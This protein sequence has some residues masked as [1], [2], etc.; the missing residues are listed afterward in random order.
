MEWATRSPVLD[1]AASSSRPT[2]P[3]RSQCWG[4]AALAERPCPGRS[5]GK[6]PRSRAR[7]TSGAGSCHTVWSRAG[8]VQEQGRR[9]SSIEG[10]SAGSRQHR[11]C[12]RQ[13]LSCM[14]LPLLRRGQR[15]LRSSVRS[16][17]SLVRSTGRTSSSPT[18]ASASS[19]A[20]ICLMRRCWPGGSPGSLASPT[21]ARCE[22]TFSP[23]YQ[24]GAGLAPALD[25][26]AQ[27]SRLRPWS[28]RLP[29]Q[30]R[31]D[32]R[33]PGYFTQATAA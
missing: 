26:E 11:P 23:L 24:P 21:V 10:A 22:N 33:R 13:T 18:P 16:C 15:W 19:S 2:Q 7:Q 14:G 1:A 9:Q 25:A 8:A 4:A 27:N 30:S 32:S 5:S 29:E 17:G 6:A 20:L 31:D 28:C 12:S 3:A